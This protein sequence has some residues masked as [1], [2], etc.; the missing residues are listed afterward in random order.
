MSSDTARLGVYY[1][2]H[3]VGR[4]ELSE[5]ETYSFQY[6]QG[7]LADK[8]RFPLSFALPLRGEAFGNKDTLAF[9]ENLL[10]EE[11]VAKALERRHRMSSPFQFLQKFGKDCA[12]AVT[13]SAQPPPKVGEHQQ[14]ELIDESVLRDALDQ[15]QS[16]AEVISQTVPGYLSLAGAQDKFPAIFHDGEFFI[17]LDGSP[18]PHIVKPAIT[19]QSINGSVFNELYVMRLAGAVGLKTPHCSVHYLG[20]H[21][22]YVIERYDRRRDERGQWYRL[23][24]EDFC[25]AQGLRAS[26]KYESAGGPS[27]S[28]HFNLIKK[29]SHPQSRAADIEMF[30]RWLAFNL[31]IGNN[32]CHAKNLS[33]L[34]EGGQTALAPFYDLL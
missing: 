2:Q 25:Q 11:E 27:L 34:H 24:Q 23:H 26:S 29:H 7:W 32:D 31:L 20:D 12:G 5:Q 19:R 4:I 13:I 17:P 8:G 15:Q 18:T 1:N 9:F 33:F 21:P 14:K 22:L 10:P 30:F 28:D 3:L 6:A 16:L